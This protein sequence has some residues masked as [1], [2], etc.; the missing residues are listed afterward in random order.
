M[1]FKGNI[2]KII[3]TTTGTKSDGSQWIRQ[4]FIF[5]YFERPE[6]RYSDKVVLSIMNDRIKE[7]DL[8]END[9]VTVGFSHSIRE[10][11][12]RYYNDLRV[13]RIQKETAAVPQEPK[14][15]QQNQL[16]F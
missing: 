15:E 12:G 11:Q 5:E 7:Y 1:D 13:Y 10:Y 16:P 6:D 8:H 9:K 2:Y 3:G 14:Q 4:E